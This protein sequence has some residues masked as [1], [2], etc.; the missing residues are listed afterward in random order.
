MLD[1]SRL[2]RGAR[3]GAAAGLVWCLGE[4]ALR[5]VLGTPYSDARLLG[6][7]LTRGPLWW[8]AGTLLHIGNGAAFGAAF[9]TLGGHGW[10]QG[11]LAAQAESVALWPAMALVDRWHPDRRDGSWPPLLRNGRVFVQET[12]MHGLFGA[13]LGALVE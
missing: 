5:R 3:A 7:P 10:R 2:E 8:P 13:I 4:Q 11:V 12:I 1:R 9:A 6:A